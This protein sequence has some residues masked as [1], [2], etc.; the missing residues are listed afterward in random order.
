VTTKAIIDLNLLA[1][2]IADGKSKSAAAD[3]LGISEVTLSN[4]IKLDNDVQAAFQRGKT[5]LR[6]NRIINANDGQEKSPTALVIEAVMRGV[7]TRGRLL[8]ETGLT[9]VQLERELY[10][11][12]NE[13]RILNANEDPMGVEHL[14]LRPEFKEALKPLP[15][16]VDVPS[17]P[18]PADDHIPAPSPAKATRRSTKKTA[19]VKKR[20]RALSTSKKA[21]SKKGAGKKRVAHRGV[22]EDNKGQQ[23]AAT[24]QQNSSPPPAPAV[25]REIVIAL[26]AAHVEFAYQ[27][28]WGE[29]SP[30]FSS[31]RNLLNE[32]LLSA[33]VKANADR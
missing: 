19:A 23:A 25:P 12:V 2:L 18:A 1:N 5:R 3:E 11:L 16:V 28:C 15:E 13:T 9:S 14:D 24:L 31:V 29:P 26:E 4:R 8:K 21:A 10:D 20:A 17:P 7:D 22:A 32:A 27:Q 30:H 33:T 6:L